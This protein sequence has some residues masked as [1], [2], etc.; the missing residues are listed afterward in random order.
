MTYQVDG[1][2]LGLKSCG[3]VVAISHVVTVV[4]TENNCIG[5]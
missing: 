4:N 2:L 5:F 3:E 1:V